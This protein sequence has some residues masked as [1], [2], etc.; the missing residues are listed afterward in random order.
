M[1][2]RKGAAVADRT[3]NWLIGVIIV[4]GWGL[5][6]LACGGLYTAVICPTI[7]EVRDQQETIGNVSRIFMHA[8]NEYTLLVSEDGQEIPKSILLARDPTFVQDVPAGQA[9]WV[10]A[11]YDRRQDGTHVYK[12]AVFHIRTME[13]LDGGGWR[14][15]KGEHEMTSVV[16]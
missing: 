3:A 7:I 11:V 14:R 10:Q 13:D 9:M 16:D 6:I 5:I 2:T 15:L 4:S 12:S 8:L 1:G